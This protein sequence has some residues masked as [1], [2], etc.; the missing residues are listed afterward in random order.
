MM[1]TP[2][3]HRWGANIR[4]S[5]TSGGGGGVFKWGGPQKWGEHPKMGGK[6]PRI[7]EGDK[8]MGRGTQNGGGGGRGDPKIEGG[9]Q[10]VGRGIP[11]WGGTPK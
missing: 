2:P 4:H 5:S 7:E 1:Q 3:R 9:A 10:K 6:K 8:K 11:K